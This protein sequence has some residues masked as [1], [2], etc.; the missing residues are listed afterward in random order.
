[1]AVDNIED[2]CLKRFKDRNKAIRHP[3]PNPD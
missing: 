2:K 3:V 1:M